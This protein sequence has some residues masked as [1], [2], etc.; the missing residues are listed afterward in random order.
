MK[1]SSTMK[2]GSSFLRRG[3]WTLGMAM[4]FVHQAVQA[5]PG[6]KQANTEGG[7]AALNGTSIA[8]SL[9]VL[10]MIFMVLAV[11]GVLGRMMY[12]SCQLIA[13]QQRAA[14]DAEDAARGGLPLSGASPA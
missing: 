3:A 5:C 8:F 13:A 7:K 1:Y 2:T 10:F 12:R 11:L 9:G 4:I 6:C 14:M